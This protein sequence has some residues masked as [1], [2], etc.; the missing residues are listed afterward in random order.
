MPGNHVEVTCR[1]VDNAGG[2]GL[3]QVTGI[4]KEVIIMKGFIEEFKEFISRGNVMDMAVGIMIGGAFTAIVTSLVDNIIS[5]ILGVFGGLN[6]DQLK[7]S[8]GGEVTLMYGKFIT[9]VI[10]FLIMAFILFSIIKA[11]NAASSKIKKPE[12]EEAPTTKMCPYCMCDDVAIGA[13]KC[14]HC[15]SVLPV[16]ETAEQA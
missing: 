6:F 15:A 11:L 9:A 1:G 5:P 10:N 16:E 7:V 8:L 14:P 13:T 3:L 2:R 4:R 12:E